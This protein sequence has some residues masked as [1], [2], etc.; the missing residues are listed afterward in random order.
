MAWLS[1]GSENADFFFC[2]NPPLRPIWGAPCE[3]AGDKW[4]VFGRVSVA[5]MLSFLWNAGIGRTIPKP[6]FLW[7]FA[8]D[9][10]LLLH[11]HS[12]SC[13]N[14][15]LKHFSDSHCGA[16][17]SWRGQS[18]LSLL[19]SCPC[20]A[21][22]AQQK[23]AV[24]RS[25]LLNQVALCHSAEGWV[26][27]TSSCL[28]PFEIK[29]GKL[30][31]EAKERHDKEFLF[32][33]LPFCAP[34]QTSLI[35]EVAYSLKNSKNIKRL[36]QRK[37]KRYGRCIRFPTCKKYILSNNLAKRLLELFSRS[38]DVTWFLSVFHK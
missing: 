36:V 8:A 7:V 14:L 35:L 34:V 31:L 27:H 9:K 37:P 1:L 22:A 10:S 2:L 25:D 32:P 33:S 6:D 24:T 17:Q 29:S 23:A 11:K 19:T 5:F 18:A 4:N 26:A 21:L 12:P 28:Q 38:L 13:W 16:R 15:I 20:A 3:L 30:Q